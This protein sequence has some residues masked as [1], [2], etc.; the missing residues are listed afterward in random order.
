MCA[1]YY[2]PLQWPEHSHPHH[3]PS[4]STPL[5]EHVPINNN[6]S[7]HMA[8]YSKFYYES[9]NYGNC[10]TNVSPSPSL[11]SSE[12]PKTMGAVEPLLTAHQ[13]HSSAASPV[14]S[15]N[16]NKSSVTAA[17]GNGKSKKKIPK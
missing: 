9:G 8:N 11:V 12:A 13:R 10:Q 4:W 15:S 7:N 17:V 3:H 14:Y 6:N 5:S 16:R 1:A 2:P